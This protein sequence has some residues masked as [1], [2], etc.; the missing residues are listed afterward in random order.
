MRVRHD[1]LGVFPFIALYSYN[2]AMPWDIEDDAP[3]RETP[4]IRER[5]EEILAIRE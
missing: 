3:K 5:V 1:I 4:V 2:P